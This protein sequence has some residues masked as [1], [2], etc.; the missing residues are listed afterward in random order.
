MRDFFRGQKTVTILARI[1]RRWRH[2]QTHRE[3]ALNRR[4]RSLFGGHFGDQRRDLFE[5]HFGDAFR[6]LKE[7]KKRP[8]I[9]AVTDTGRV[10]YRWSDRD[11]E[12]VRIRSRFRCR[13]LPVGRR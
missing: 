11:L 8:T 4:E 13:L 9:D 5:W 2:Q 3:R 6:R 1:V 7:R 10:R 12:P